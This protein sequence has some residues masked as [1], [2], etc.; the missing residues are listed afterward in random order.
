[1]LRDKMEIGIEAIHDF[2]IFMFWKFF[3]TEW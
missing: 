3:F 1:M 2:Y